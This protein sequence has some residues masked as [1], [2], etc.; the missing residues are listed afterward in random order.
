M[1]NSVQAMRTGANIPE[2]R[3][4]DSEFHIAVADASANSYLQQ[5]IEDARADMF[6]PLDALD[7]IDITLT[8]SVNDHSQIIAAI[9]AGD[10]DL[11]QAMMA[12]H[13]ESAR[14]E[15]R[16]TITGE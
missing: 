6:R 10:P 16:R 8:E 15:I 3:K 11:A 5:S 2:F 9:K 7:D 13:I 12:E 4:A 1:W 14:K